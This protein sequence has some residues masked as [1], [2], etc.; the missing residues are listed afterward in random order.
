MIA[1]RSRRTLLSFLCATAALTGCAAGPTALNDQDDRISA[2]A[3]SVDRR[4]PMPWNRIQRTDDVAIP[5]TQST[6]SSTAR[7]K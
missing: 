3:D 2:D 7:L 1:I 5:A 6:A 4:P